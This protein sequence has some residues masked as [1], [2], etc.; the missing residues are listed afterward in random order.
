M[1]RLFSMGSW[2]TALAGEQPEGQLPLS[3]ADPSAMVTTDGEEEDAVTFGYIIAKPEI[4][5]SKTNRR[6]CFVYT[7][8]N[9][10][11]REGGRRISIT[12]NLWGCYAGNLQFVTLYTSPRWQSLND[13]TFC[14]SDSYLVR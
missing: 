13:S 6:V 7:V 11:F 4:R 3:A 1:F 12:L 5:N 2:R 10:T 9:D 14:P 8:V